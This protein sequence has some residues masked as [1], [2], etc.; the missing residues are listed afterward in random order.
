D[1][2]SVQ[3]EYYVFPNRNAIDLPQYQQALRYWIMVS[4]S[5][6]GLGEDSRVVYRGV[7]VGRVLSTDYIPPG[8]NLLDRSLDLPV[9]IEINPGRL[10]LPDN[11]EGAERAARDIET[12]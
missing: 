10:G 1:A 5:V 12:W 11:M 9:L 2:P 4:D 3:T 8:R 6:G 7:Q